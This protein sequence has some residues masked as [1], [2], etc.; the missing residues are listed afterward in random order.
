MFRSAAVFF[1][2]ILLV[3]TGLHA[4]V[5][6]RLATV[7]WVAQHISRALLFGLAAFLWISY[8]GAR[9]LDRFGLEAIGRPI[10]WIGAFW[11]GTLFL[12]FLCFF[13]VDLVTGFGH[14]LP[15]LAPAMRTFALLGTVVLVVIALAQALRAPAVREYEVTLPGLPAQL[16]GTTVA[17]VSDTHL[18]N[19][20]GQDWLE[21]RLAQVEAL[22]PDLLIMAGDIVEG[23]TPREG[24]LLPVLRRFHAPLGVWAVTGNHEF[25]AGLDHSLRLFSDAGWTTLRD[26]WFEVRPGL[27]IAGVDDLTARRRFRPDIG[28]FVEKALANRPLNAGVVYVSHSPLQAERA[29]ALGAGVMLCGHTHHGQIWPFGYFVRA[30]Y[31]LFTGRHEI[32]GMTAIVGNGTGTWGPRMRL[33]QRGEIL[34]V[35]LRSPEK[36]MAAENADQR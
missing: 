19:M 12:A 35:T 10:E 1:L 7:P 17:V 8:L 20:I 23:D 2:V 18:G 14:F 26:R 36:R 27:V 34:R 25:Y 5:F 3:W 9:I 22:K 29:A 21:A 30:V 6:W 15:R 13:A 24:K 16:D 32:R 33:W 28:V 31:P 11:L 4:Y